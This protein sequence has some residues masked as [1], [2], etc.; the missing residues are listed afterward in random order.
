MKLFYRIIKLVSSLIELLIS[1]Q[2]K[3]KILWASSEIF[4]QVQRTEGFLIAIYIDFENSFEYP[5]DNSKVT[6]HR[7]FGGDKRITGVAKNK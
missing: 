1:S 7:R 4:I 5:I 2:C 6:P 3:D